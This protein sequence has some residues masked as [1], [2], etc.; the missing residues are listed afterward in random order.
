MSDISFDDTVSPLTPGDL[1]NK[2]F[3]SIS[4]PDW[5]W[6]DGSDLS[7][8]SMSPCILSNPSTPVNPRKLPY[9]ARG[10]GESDED[11]NTPK[12]I[13][14]Q[15]PMSKPRQVYLV[16]YSQADVLKVQSR[17]QF[18]H[19]VTSEFNRD[20][21][22]VEHWVVSAELHRQH[23]F[24]Y[25]LA[26]KL[27]KQRR[28]K[29]VR[30]L[31]KKKYDIDVDFKEWQDNYYQAYTYVT[32]LD[33]HYVTSENHPVLSNA[34][35]TCKA[36]KAKRSLATLKEEGPT[37][38]S[39]KQKKYKTPPLRN[40]AVGDII[41]TNNIRTSKELYSFAKNQAKE[42]KTDLQHFLYKR[43][44]AKQLADLISTVWSIEEADLE[45]SR[46]RKSRLDILREAKVQPCAVETDSGK[47]LRC[48]GSW[49]PAALNTL[50]K[51]NVS[52][53]HF[54]NLVLTCLK[55]G[56]GKGRNLMICGPSNCAKSFVLLP[57]TKIF[58]CFTNPSEG[59]YNWVNAPQK[60]VIFLN[61][62]RY[63]A[64]GE[65]RVMAWNMFLNLLEGTVVNISMPKNFHANDFE[66][67][68]RQPIF[69][70]SD[71]PIVR[72]KNGSYDQ[73][74]TQQMAQ[75][76]KILHF[77]HQYLDEECNYDLIPCGA[78]FAKLILDED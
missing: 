28:F 11:C 30:N 66:W 51:N 72:I 65:R 37:A 32:K 48:D 62:I 33:S 75:R 70:T 57:L 17:E 56:R 21:S 50:H 29:Q 77:Q 15:G 64:D 53:K 26:I 9:S 40:E 43:P 10:L 47:T 7:D 45:L 36:T 31:L 39:Q 1:T 59:T 23:G 46:E 52:R 12:K 44:N 61:D 78:C 16:T 19:F 60:E 55:Y 69:A 73:G 41:R 76:W 24:H 4:T 5:K 42:G 74:E 38:S 25:H 58:K 6:E 63:D 18:A 71:K 20:D 35:S 54:S 34:P 2:N 49:L 3:M 22:V 27:N 67:S 68:E 13:K 8:T 14:K